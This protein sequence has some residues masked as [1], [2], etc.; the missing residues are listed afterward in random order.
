MHSIKSNSERTG[1]GFTDDYIIHKLV[2]VNSGSSAYTEIPMP[3][4]AALFGSNNEGK[5]SSLSTLKLFV[6]PE[7]TFKGCERK[8][9]FGGPSG[10]F[11]GL[12][13]FN[14]YFPSNS[15]FMVCEA[16][17]RK[18]RFCIMLK[19]SREEL[20]YE[21]Y[22]VPVAYDK[23]KDLFW[24]FTSDANDGYGEPI[25][26]LKAADVVSALKKLGG[27]LISGPRDIRESI[28]SAPGIVD[29]LSR[30]C[31]IPLTEKGEQG[32]ADALAGLLGLA[33]DISGRR[34]SSLPNAVATIIAGE[35]SSKDTPLDIDIGK[36]TDDFENLKKQ[37]AH[38]G[39]IRDQVSTWLSVQSA[40][41][42]YLK[43]RRAAIEIGPVLKQSTASLLDESSNVLSEIK[44][45]LDDHT[46]ALQDILNQRRQA[47]SVVKELKSTTKHNAK[48][49]E[50]TRETL[51]SIAELEDEAGRAGIT[52]ES[53]I[54]AWLDGLITDFKA[55]V[56]LLAGE[57]SDSELLATKNAQHTTLKQEIERC[58]Q[59]IASQNKRMFRHLSPYA[60]NHLYSLRTSLGTL[61][62]TP[63]PSEIETIEGFAK[64]ISS[65][66]T[67]RELTFLDQTIIGAEKLKYDDDAERDILVEKVKKLKSE[68]AQLWK[69]IRSLNEKLSSKSGVDSRKSALMDAEKE[70]IQAIND[71]KIFRGKE[72]TLQD[73]SDR[74]EALAVSEE[75]LEKAQASLT[76]ITEKFLAAN[77]ATEASRANFDAA[78]EKHRRIEAV[79][80]D[81]DRCI[82]SQPDFNSIDVT[83]GAGDLIRDLEAIKEKYKQLDDAMSAYP[84]EKQTLIAGLASLERAGI[85]MGR[86]GVAYSPTL[87]Y[88]ELEKI[89]DAL[90]SEFSNLDR[91]EAKLKR[92]IFSHN[93]ENASRAGRLTQIARTISQFEDQINAEFEQYTI[94]NLDSIRISIGVDKRFSSLVADLKDEKFSG[95]ELKNDAFYA[96]LNAFSEE[97]FEGNSRKIQ[98][99]KV[100]TKIDFKFEVG[101]ATTDKGQ[102]NGT[103]CMLNAG[104]LSILLKRL[105]PTNVALTFPVVFDEVTSLDEDN[106]ET[107][108][109]MV[110][111]HGFVLFVAAP[112]NNGV[113]GSEI[114]NWYD[115]S[116]REVRGQPIVG[117]CKVIHY[118]MREGITDISEAD[119]YAG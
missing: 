81:I 85:S 3:K 19:R 106:L 56:A 55:D 104:L 6:L 73:A 42:N 80:L 62:A 71:R 45:V 116:M 35:H 46:E 101:G 57:A 103:S 60:Q 2:F 92:D 33:F 32:S 53:G 64:L 28:Y 27:E 34:E 87:D 11:T 113:I 100:I 48:E 52:S 21:R 18:G 7:Q 44:G 1:L 77:K 8:F 96:R 111:D 26:D 89:M 17:N 119:A 97:F 99:N 91:N 59:L 66:P 47:E 83:V 82:K 12:Q 84:V 102:S 118:D 38:I 75:E 25:I 70:L 5:T 41:A 79:S 22:G 63:S 74:E 93:N 76:T 78:T 4:T 72:Q 23:I 24:N 90:S 110:E 16:E 40:Y 49:L 37:A 107:I 115:L 86:S 36:I 98:L 13:S 31:L 43:A 112:Y 65:G 108:I 105:I 30:Y 15:S 114:E 58:E 39:T 109:R 29:D 69:S 68:Q 117:S 51:R 67:G 50:S 54:D 95:T 61:N 88:E 14:W 20:G 94:S 10:L 9:G